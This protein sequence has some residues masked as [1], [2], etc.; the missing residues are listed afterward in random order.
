MR[1]V[2]SSMS[3]DQLKARLQERADIVTARIEL[4]QK[5][6][7]SGK[8]INDLKH[9]LAVV[10]RRLKLLNEKVLLGRTGAE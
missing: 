7:S 2:A 3:L 5:S 8:I 4:A 1:P 6:G 10:G 9:E